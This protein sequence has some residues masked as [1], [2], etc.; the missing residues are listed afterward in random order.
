MQQHNQR[1]RYINRTLL[2][3]FLKSSS[4]RY[5][6]FLLRTSAFERQ[7]LGSTSSELNFW[8]SFHIIDA[9]LV[10]SLVYVLI[11][12]APSIRSAYSLLPLELEVETLAAL[13]HS[14]GNQKTN[15]A[16]DFWRG[17]EIS[18]IR[19]H[20]ARLRLHKSAEMGIFFFIPCKYILHR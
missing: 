3:L 7:A 8:T 6:C 11:P 14:Y 20:T 16:V 13:N 5:Y 18:R 10:M 12:A 4:S 1:M 15:D 2:N 9:H 19:T 17:K